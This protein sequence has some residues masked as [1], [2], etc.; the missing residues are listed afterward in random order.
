[1]NRL[2]HLVPATEE[3]VRAIIQ[4]S[5]NKSC[6]LDHLPTRL[7]KGSLDE[8]LSLITDIVNASMAAGSVPKDFKSARIR[9]LLKKSGLDQNLLKNYRPVSNLPFISKILEKVVDK[10]LE[11]HLTDN[12]LHEGFQ[13]AYRKFHSTESALLKVQND[14]LQFLHNNCVTVLV[15]LDLSAAFDTIDHQTLLLRLEKL[16]GIT[17]NPLAWMSSYL[18]DRFQTVCVDGKLVA[19][20]YEV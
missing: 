11:R 20:A 5:P 6:E 13:S 12:K 18:S 9:P 19:C 1:M 15:L 7:L 14:I 2:D 10:L 8:L 3:E 17:D 4:K 16:F